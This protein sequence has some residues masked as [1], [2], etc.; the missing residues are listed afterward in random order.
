MK[1]HG[2]DQ[3]WLIDEGEGALVAAAIHDGHAART[4]A[5][6]L[7][8]LN[9]Q[10]RLRE[11]DPYTGEWAR[12]CAN[13][14]VGTRSRFEVDLNRPREKAVYIEP[15]D[16][17]GLTVWK[18]RP[19]EAMID[20]SLSLYD[21]FYDR[22][23]AA[24]SRLERQHGHFIV[25]DLHSYNHRRQGADAEPE[26]PTGNPEVNVGTG[27]LNRNRWGGVVDGFMEDLA[28]YSF[29]GRQLD[30]RENVRFQGGYFARWSHEQ[31]PDAACVLAVEFKKFFMDE[32]TGEPDRAQIDEIAKALAVTLPGL[33]ATL[34]SA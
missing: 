5:M 12:L 8:A 1:D 13:R 33:R 28:A 24:F 23:R 18:H 19:A 22:V 7:F 31:F 11:E 16:A 2:E 20:R 29:A 4:E 10:E 17:W 32:W 3:G 6:E 27:T 26:D 9:S 14:I 25:L 30:V 34:E 21:G 15:A